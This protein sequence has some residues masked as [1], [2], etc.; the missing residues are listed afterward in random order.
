MRRG[1]VVAI[2]A[3]LVIGCGS[4]PVVTPAASTPGSAGSPGLAANRTLPPIASLPPLPSPTP[5]P[6]ATPLPSAGP[7]PACADGDVLTSFHEPAD[8]ART[9]LD[10]TFRLDAD[11]VPPDLVSVSKAGIPGA[12]QVRSLVIDDLGAMYRT[13]KRA[14]VRFGVNS[15]YRSYD[16]QAKVF[17]TF[18]RQDGLAFALKSAARPGHSEHQLGTVI[19]VTGDTVWLSKHAW[20]YGWVPSYAKRWS[21]ATTCYKPEAWHFRYVGR[22]A[23]AAWHVS[24]VSLREWLW[25]TQP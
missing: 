19:D 20:E 9:I 18:R 13:A 1:M 22:A 7:L 4:T 24:G 12:A 3:V 21:P 16:M 8:W 5:T 11:F 2:V 14:G 23:A 25:E 17:E 10:T 6:V 15:A